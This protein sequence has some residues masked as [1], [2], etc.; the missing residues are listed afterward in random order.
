MTAQ[1]KMARTRMTTAATTIICSRDMC[2]THTVAIQLRPSSGKGKGERAAG[3]FVKDAAGYGSAIAFLAARPA[4]CVSNSTPKGTIGLICTL[5]YWVDRLSPNSLLLNLSKGLASVPPQ[6]L[7]PRDLTKRH[8][9]EHYLPSA[10]R[11]QS[12]NRRPHEYQA[13]DLQA[14]KGGLLLREF[15]H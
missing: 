1:P 7:P 9:H 4:S 8:Y 14:R 10:H 2:F 3:S 5:T 12:G 11:R 6:R 13:R 15:A